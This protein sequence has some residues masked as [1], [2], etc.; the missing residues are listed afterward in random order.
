MF[1]MYLQYSNLLIFQYQIFSCVVLEIT[2]VCCCA[3]AMCIYRWRTMRIFWVS[4]V[5]VYVTR[6]ARAELQYLSVEVA[7]AKL[8][9]FDTEQFKDQRS[10]THGAASQQ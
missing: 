5:V 9:L 6:L 2:P 8:S 1:R 3:F 4:L 10:Q 7:I